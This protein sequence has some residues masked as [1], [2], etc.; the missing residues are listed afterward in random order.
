MCLTAVVYLCHGVCG[1]EVFVQ[2]DPDLPGC[3]GERV[4]PSKSVCPVYR[5]EIWGKIILPINR[6]SSKLG[7]GKSGFD[8]TVYKSVWGC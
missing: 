5:G 8:C 7:P 2:S 6:G 1:R 4:F 3:S